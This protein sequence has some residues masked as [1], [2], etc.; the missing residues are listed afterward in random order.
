V[1]KQH[2]RQSKGINYFN[3]L[4]DIKIKDNTQ[5]PDWLNDIAQMLVEKPNFSK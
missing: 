3:A 5:I 4:V 1:I 2:I